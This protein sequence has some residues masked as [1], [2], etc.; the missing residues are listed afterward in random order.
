MA[1]SAAWSHVRAVPVLTPYQCRVTVAPEMAC[2][3]NRVSTTVTDPDGPVAVTPPGSVTRNAKRYTVLTEPVS[4]CVNDARQEPSAAWRH[5]GVLDGRAGHVRRRGD[6]LH[7]D[8]PD[9][10]TERVL[11]HQWLE[12][13]GRGA[14][15]SNATVGA[16]ATGAGQKGERAEQQRSGE[17]P[18]QRD[19]A[20]P[21][22]LGI[23]SALVVAPSNPVRLSAHEASPC[24]PGAA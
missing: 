15:R 9:A 8:R 6:E 20:S 14:G 21:A 3:A 17:G 18:G 1:A 24:E 4:A 10:R 7:T 19:H 2:Q 22:N 16:A 11:E 12:E 13:H 23:P 5:G